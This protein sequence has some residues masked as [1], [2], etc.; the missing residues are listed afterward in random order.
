MASMT[1]KGWSGPPVIVVEYAG[2]K[3][4][5]DGHH[6]I[7]AARK[8]GI[9]VQYRCVN[10]EQLKDFGFD[11]VEQVVIAHAE[12]GYNRIRFR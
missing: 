4:V 8:A 10:A 9:S 11:S 2:D 5:L 3:Y 7:Y 12:G 1:R 6:R